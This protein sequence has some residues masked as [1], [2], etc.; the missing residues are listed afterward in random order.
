M[1]FQ[2]FVRSSVAEWIVRDYVNL[3]YPLD[4][5]YD[6]AAEEKAEWKESSFWKRRLEDEMNVESP[7]AESNWV[8]SVLGRKRSMT[9]EENKRMD[10]I[11]FDIMRLAQAQVET[12]LA[13][14]KKLQAIKE[15]EKPCVQLLDTA[16][17]LPSISEQIP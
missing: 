8:V 2:G 15:K 3:T 1:H 14:V 5:A 6:V 11:P 16:Q 17:S 9:K 7:E 13:T 12:A 4:Q 10:G